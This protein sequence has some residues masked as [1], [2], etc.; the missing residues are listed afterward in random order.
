M[1]DDILKGHSL[2][3]FHVLADPVEYNDG[4]IQGISND[5]H[6]RTND[7]KVDL[8]CEP[9]GIENRQKS[10]RDDDIVHQAGNSAD[11]KFK[12]EPDGDIKEDR[13]E[14]LLPKQ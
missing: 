10:Y 1:V 13:E 2:Q 12:L 5:R 9:E 3:D 6:D 8:D 14:K 4:I 11:C 7:L